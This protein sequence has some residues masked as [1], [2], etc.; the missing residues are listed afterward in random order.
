MCL[1]YPKNQTQR[2]TLNLP[3]GFPDLRLA[4][5]AA[6]FS[7]LHGQKFIAAKGTPFD[8]PPDGE[9][10]ILIVIGYIIDAIRAAG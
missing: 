5:N 4:L 3:F 7:P 10:I 8:I 6:P 9:G 2:S 1:S